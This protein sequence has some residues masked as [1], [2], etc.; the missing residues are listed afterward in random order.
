MAKNCSTAFL[1]ALAKGVITPVLLF[2]GQFTSG[3][4][5]MSTYRRVIAWNGQSFLPGAGFVGVG[6]AT[7]SKG[8]KAD[9]LILTCAAS[10]ALT[11]DWA[12]YINSECKHSFPGTLWFALID[13]S[14]VLVADPV[15]IFTG[16]MDVVAIQ[17]QAESILLQLTYETPLIRKQAN[18][19]RYTQEDQLAEYPNDTGFHQVNALQDLDLDNLLRPAWVGTPNNYGPPPGSLLP[20]GM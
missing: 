15:Q 13:D 9:N 6:G 17:R 19:R 12:A 14:D 11:S 20:Y 16:N 3:W 1:A 7:D 18:Q 10:G 4:V 5:Y 8:L 2:A